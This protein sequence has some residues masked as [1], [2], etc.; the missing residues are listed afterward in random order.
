MSQSTWYSNIQRILLTILVWTLILELLA[1]FYFLSEK[2]LDRFELA[3]TLILFI[4]NLIA[5]IYVVRNLAKR[6][7]GVDI[8]PTSS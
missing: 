3:Y 5:V 8:I 6:V 4:V 7:R 2:R 1:L